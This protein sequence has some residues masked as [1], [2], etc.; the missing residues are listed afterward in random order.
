MSPFDSGGSSAPLR[1]AFGM[2]AVGDI[3]NRVTALLDEDTATGHSFARLLNDRFAKVAVPNAL[4]NRLD[5]LSNGNA[6]LIANLPRALQDIIRADIA[7]F[8][9]QCPDD[10]DLRGASLG[11]LVLVGGFLRNARDIN[12]TLGNLSS[13]ARIRGI[14]RPVAS[15]TAH[16][17]ATLTNNRTVH[18]QHRITSRRGPIDAPIQSLYAIDSLESPSAIEIEALPLAIKLVKQAD[19]LCYPMGSF[20]TSVAAN[21]LPMGIGTAVAASSARKVYV[22]STGR[23]PE[24]IG[25]TLSRAIEALAQLGRRDAGDGHSTVDFVNTVVLDPEHVRYGLR[26]DLREVRRAGVEVIERRLVGN[27]NEYDAARLSR[28]LLELAS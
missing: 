22:P 9:R 11:N 14:I 4:R 23:D 24:Q 21:L 5:M 15:T 8:A 10:F 16:I 17:A 27:Q 7:E 25:M 26:I 6:A 18:G 20:W 28:L 12:R 3:R 13:A 2:L 19:L 1:K